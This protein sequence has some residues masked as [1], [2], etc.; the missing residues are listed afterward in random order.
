[1]RIRENYHVSPEVCVVERLLLRIGSLEMQQM[2]CQKA[3]IY[4]NGRLKANL[5]FQ[6]LK[7]KRFSTLLLLS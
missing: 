3:C 1:M 6:E 7:W 5:Y 2:F 4:C